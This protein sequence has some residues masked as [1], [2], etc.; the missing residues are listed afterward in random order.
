M[1]AV[2]TW[3]V[4]EPLPA[5]HPHSEFRV[6]SSP[7][8]AFKTYGSRVLVLSLGITEPHLYIIHSH[9]PRHTIYII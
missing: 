1:L 5:L 9:V 2:V 4:A 6:L 3:C 7:P 8:L